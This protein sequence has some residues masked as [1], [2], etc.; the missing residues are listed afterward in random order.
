MSD[1]INFKCPDCGYDLVVRSPVKIEKADD[2][3]NTT[4]SNCGRT[5]HKDDIIRQA[6]E[7]AE[8]LVRDML[9]KHF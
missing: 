2:I 4:C 1:I 7:H 6:R 9:R 3:D 8:N 5:I